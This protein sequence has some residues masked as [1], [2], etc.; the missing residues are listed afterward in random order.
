MPLYAYIG[1]D[2]KGKKLRGL[3]ESA[4]EKTAVDQLLREGWLIAKIKLSTGSPWWRFRLENKVSSDDF[5]LFLLRLENLLEAG[6]SLFAALKTL[7]TQAGSSKLR[8]LTENISEKV[9]GGQSFSE[10]ASSA[11]D[12]FSDLDCQMI[13]VGE[14]SGSLPQALRHIIILHEASEELRH[15]LQ[16]ALTY[17]AILIVACVGVISI[18]IGWL[19]PA[20]TV[21]FEK[22]G[23]P[24]PL[25]TRILN[26][27]A[28]WMHSH[29]IF[30]FIAS[31]VLI[32]A[33]RLFLQIERIKFFWDRAWLQCPQIGTLL[34]RVEIARWGRTTA[35]MLASGVPLVQTL[36]TVQKIP[37]NFAF[38]KALA[39][40]FEHVVGGESLAVS[41]E[42]AGLFPGDVVQMVATGEMSGALDKMLR[43]ISEFYD[44]LIAR[45]LKHLTG[46]IEPIFVLVMGGLVG[47]IML[48]ILLPIFDMIKIFKP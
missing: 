17:P 40:A 48:S 30:L 34:K 47:F 16:S 41:L 42:R 18:A 13:R 32:V 3:I 8:R 27:V 26:G 33:V 21:I 11:P 37:S 5:V 14:T 7:A 24:L 10:A 19:I 4:S 39:D 31:S 12:V 36:D 46:M 35:L 22:A 38:R 6:V 29:S 1:R 15:K 2:R 25:P 45:A 44:E 23:V 43:K 28:M 9:E 20:F